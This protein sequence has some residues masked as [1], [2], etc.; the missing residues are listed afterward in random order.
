MHGEPEPFY[1]T[2]CSV[3]VECP[4]YLVFA[5]H[6]KRTGVHG[7]LRVCGFV[8]WHRVNF[9]GSLLPPLCIA[10]FGMVAAN[11][12][13]LDAVL[14]SLVGSIYQEHVFSVINMY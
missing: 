1:A 2:V 3:S 6:N 11:V 14:N 9:T 12:T 8:T 7:L 4:V 13:P 5:V 10:S